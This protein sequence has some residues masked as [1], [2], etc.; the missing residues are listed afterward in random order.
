MIIR[1]AVPAAFDPISLD[2]VK[3]HCRIDSDHE[4]LLLLGLIAAAC[5]HGEALTRRVFC[6][7]LWEMTIN[8]PIAGALLIPLAPCTDCISVHVDD[9]IVSPD[10]YSLCPSALTPME[11]PM[12]G[13][14]T[15]HE[16]FPEGESV[17]VT[18]HAGWAAETLP[19]DI[20]AWL[21]VRVA[22][23]YEQRENHIVGVGTTHMPRS[24]VDSL[25][26]PYIIPE[27]F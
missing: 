1:C 20:K 14:L 10:H 21:R 7:S 15:L 13:I 23:L 8:G 22:S 24:F 18:V 25:L 27:G 17:R 16:G 5:R 26:D 3:V 4:D 12:R 11:F 9:L 2:E 19:D 6:R